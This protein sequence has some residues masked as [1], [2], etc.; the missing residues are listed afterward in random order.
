M[1]NAIWYTQELEKVGFSRGQA[2]L[3]VRLVIDV[4]NENFATKAD[5]KELGLDL[6]SEMR[7]LE[8]KLIIKLSTILGAMMTFA[9]GATATI[10]KVLH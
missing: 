10:V 6:R 9:I 1:F 8:Y 7:E 2:E 3:S 5:L 4:M